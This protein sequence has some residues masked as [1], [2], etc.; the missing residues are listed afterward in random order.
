MRFLAPEWLL[1]LPVLIFVGWYW[2][3][4]ELQRPL[5]VICLLLLVLLLMQPQWRRLQDGLD[6]WVLVD[7]SASARDV[8]EPQLTEWESLLKRAQ[9][10]DDKL[11]YVDYAGEVQVRN[12]GE[13][14]VFNEDN[15]HTR[16]ALAIRHALLQRD[17][18]RVTKLLVFTDGYTTDLL[19]DVEELLLQ[20]GVPLDY[21]L[22]VMDSSRDYQIKTFSLQH[23]AQVSE[24]YMLDIEIT[25]QPDAQV[26]Y[27]VFRD[28]QKIK[29]GV[30]TIAGGKARLRFTDRLAVP[31]SYLYTV[32]IFP[33]DDSIPG[34]NIK[35]QWIE[36]TSGPRILLVTNFENDPV[37]E[38]LVSRG[39]QVE[40]HTDP[41]Q[42]TP[43]RLSGSRAVILNN[44]PAHLLPPD[45]LPALEFFVRGQGGGLL[46]FG[47]RYSFGSG[48]YFRSSIEELLPVS[49]EL[50]QEHRKLAVAMA[51]VLDRS[52]SMSA[53]VTGSGSHTKM[54]LANA[55]AAATVELL[56]HS[57]AITVLAID[58]SAHVM[59]PLTAVGPNREEIQNR[60]AHIA[61]MGGGIYVYTGLKSAW[62]ELKKSPVGQRHIILFADAAD[63]EEPGDY[64]GL[65]EEMTENGTTVS[66][67]GL[68]TD[69]DVDAEFLK[70]VA[71]RGGG[72]IF[73]NADAS[74]L[75][76]LFSQETV[77]VARSAFIEEYVGLK[78]TA[79]WLEIAARP[80]EWLDRVDGYN[81][82]Y[83]R[84]GATSAAFTDDEYHA[85]LV[86]YWQRGAGRTAAVTYPIS[87]EYSMLVRRWDQYGDFV[88][89]LGRWLMGQE[90]PPGI[91]YKLAVE[92]DRLKVDLFYDASWEE[93]FAQNFPKILVSDAGMD[94]SRELVWERM[95]PG[96]FQSEAR[97]STETP[98]RG[99]IQVGGVTLPF[100]PV[101]L[102]QDS[103]WQRD[104]SRIREL[105][106]LSE[107]SGGQE[108]LNL[109]DIWQSEPERRFSDMRLP[110]L[111]AL[112]FIFL[113]EALQTRLNWRWKYKSFSAKETTVE[114]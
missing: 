36:L 73:F 106:M 71:A 37:A 20:N 57:D 79:G 47:G 72:R 1:A 3:R 22:A 12:E 19:S 65:I 11:Y 75:P 113:L 93:R 76:A 66:V 108:R 101:M 41:R 54:D 112:L 60:V 70:D 109:A 92:G 88:Q 51:I 26:P 97:L 86:A 111:I 100:G 110:V 48:G 80:L 50:R 45:F 7:R 104:A 28:K 8:I 24:P 85:P 18:S 102:G 114:Q 33:E 17:P 44:V 10:D 68:G 30:A 77:A 81:L 52:G 105:R 25:G 49:M 95:T 43:G 107:R 84:E 2:K 27:T 56:G 78:P 29:E 63:A 99:A 94:R 38:V 39:F 96:H 23:R 74:Q 6:L 69:T 55:G 90:A 42:L 9:G 91:G 59:V 82:S 87:G 61:S 98:V 13:R 103:E 21:R 64:K 35:R 46:M 31:G 16:T 32:H 5:R 34:N 40:V 83:L 62:A 4:F 53:P 14:L 58:S 15:F 89:T 67:I